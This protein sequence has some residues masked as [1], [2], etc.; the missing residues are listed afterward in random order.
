MSAAPSAQTASV[1]LSLT[2]GESANPTATFS[3][4]MAARQVIVGSGP[5][6]HWK[7]R[8]HGVEP[9]HVELYWD[10]AAL[11]IK[12]AGSLS[13]VYVGEDRADEWQQIRD[14]VEV[15]FGHAVIRARVSGH[16]SPVAKLAPEKAASAAFIDEEES[17]MVFS[18]QT[19]AAMQALPMAA[20]APMPAPMAAVAAQAPRTRQ[21][22]LNPPPHTMSPELDPSIPAKPT[23]AEATVIRASPYAAL[24]AA[25]AAS[26]PRPAAGDRTIAPGVFTPPPASVRAPSSVALSAA[27]AVGA[28]PV[29][30]VAPMAPMGFAQGGGTSVSTQS[31]PMQGGTNPGFGDDPFG[32]GAM[33]P[34]PKPPPSGLSAVPTRTWVLA[35]ITLAA[36]LPL[37]ILGPSLQQPHRGAAPSV[38]GGNNGARQ[39]VRTAGATAPTTNNILQLP[40]ARS[41]LVAVIVPAPIPMDP[42][43][44][45][46][47]PPAAPDDPIRR[48][49]QAVADNRYG[50]AIALYDQL[51]LQHPEAPLFRQFATVLRMRVNQ[52]NPCP[53]G[54]QGCT[55]SASPSPAAPS[56]PPQP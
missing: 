43:G 53:P 51:A 12:D 47:V 37:I 27:P 16:T 46:R 31:P 35:G 3:A 6:A 11:W 54:A 22:T 48:A 19:M 26:G 50:E 39:V 44:R 2:Q 40:T 41:G 52:N 36:T 23:S 5:A 29:R 56:S 33:P 18:P 1:T 13:G 45:P 32:P 55:P 7:I 8:A 4:Q 14:G 20:P 21:P 24:E 28:P 42:Q 30:S 34:P 10:G 38:A 49:A 17:T 25:M 9:S 15:M